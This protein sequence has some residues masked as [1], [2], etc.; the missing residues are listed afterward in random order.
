MKT[1]LSIGLSNI[2]DLEKLPGSRPAGPAD[3]NDP[4]R[5]KK[6]IGVPEVNKALFPAITAGVRFWPFLLVARDH[7]GRSPRR[8]EKKLAWIRGEQPRQNIGAGTLQTFRPYQSMYR[9]LA[10]SD[11]TFARPL[12]QFIDDRRRTYSGN[13][14]IF[15]RNRNEKQWRKALVNLMGRPAKQFAKLLREEA[16]RAQNKVRRDQASVNLVERLIGRILK[17]QKRSYDP[18]LWKGAACYAFLRCMY[19]IN[20]V[21]KV[22]P[23]VKAEDWATTLLDVLARTWRKEAEPLE[24]YRHAI[25]LSVSSPPWKK[26]H[27]QM[28]AENRKV[29]ADLRFHVFYN[30]YLRP[31]PK[32]W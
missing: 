27:R 14:E 29:L 20:R 31:S 11:E 22:E 4:V 26:A 28:K 32:G 21:E 15:R 6:E 1:K 9:N 25:R 18:I 10:A 23:H 24:K 12:K 17:D 7:E 3:F 19:G 30:L 2:L 16:K 8:I 13:F 5:V